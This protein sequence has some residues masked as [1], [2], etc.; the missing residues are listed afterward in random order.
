[1]NIKENITL[2]LAALIFAVTAGCTSVE[3]ESNTPMMEQEEVQAQEVQRQ[4]AQAQ[5]SMAPSP[6]IKAKKSEPIE[7]DQHKESKGSDDMERLD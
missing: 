2:W 7:R 6:S 4:E 5:E 1:M 3:P